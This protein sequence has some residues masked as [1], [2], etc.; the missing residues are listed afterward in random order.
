MFKKPTA[1]GGGHWDVAIASQAKRQVVSV[2][3]NL[4]EY[5]VEQQNK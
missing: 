1:S 3:A 5:K 4:D 2:S